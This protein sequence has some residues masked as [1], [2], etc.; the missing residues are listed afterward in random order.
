MK[1]V[2]FEAVFLNVAFKKLKNF[3]LSKNSS[4]PHKA[5]VEN[6]N[7]VTREKI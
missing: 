7:Y 3:F 1:N 4:F 6:E 2:L 5:H